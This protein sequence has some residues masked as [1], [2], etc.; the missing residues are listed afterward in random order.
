MA[1]NQELFSKGGVACMKHLRRGLRSGPLLESNRMQGH[2][3][4]KHASPGTNKGRSKMKS[5]RQRYAVNVAMRPSKQ[6]QAKPS[7]KSR[8]LHTYMT[9]GRVVV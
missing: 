3:K 5:L 9:Q 6:T 2:A 7:A 4:L 8:M 1:A